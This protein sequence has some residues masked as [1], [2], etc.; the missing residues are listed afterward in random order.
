[1][2]HSSRVTKKELSLDPQDTALGYI[3]GSQLG[4][5]LPLIPPGDIQ[6]FVETFLVVTPGIEVSTGI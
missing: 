4:V 5:I 2:R 6:K 1:M 3:N